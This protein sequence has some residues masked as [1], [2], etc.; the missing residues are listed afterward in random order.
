[1]LRKIILLPMLTFTLNAAEPIN[2][3]SFMFDNDFFAGHDMYYTHGWGLDWS[4]SYSSY[5]WS[6]DVVSLFKGW[7]VTQSNHMVGFQL[8][9][10]FFTPED[11]LDFE[12]IPDDRPYAG[13]LFTSGSVAGYSQKRADIFTMQIGLVGPSAGAEQTQNFF[14]KLLGSKEVNGW[15]NQL[16]NEL[17]IVLAYEQR[18]RYLYEGLV[19][20]SDADIITRLGGVIGNIH[21]YADVAVEARIGWKIPKDF[22]SGSLRISGVNI[23]L[24]EN[25]DPGF[26]LY[27]GFGGKAVLHNIFLDGNTFRDSHSVKKEPFVGNIRIG[28]GITWGNMEMIYGYQM[29]SKEFKL[30]AQTHEYGELS[31]H[32]HW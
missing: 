15:H 9:Q 6:K 10:Q 24:E 3:V 30:Q 12:V 20:G 4:Q 29:M 13:W 18:R 26:Y 8:A 31:L 22:G 17:G 14:H 25:E 21:T 7:G 5:Q 27:G 32:Y 23:T 2:R 19:L 28:M 16:K 1:M 11:R